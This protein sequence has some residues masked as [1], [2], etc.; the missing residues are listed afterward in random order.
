MLP[1]R[2]LSR[3]LHVTPNFICKNWKILVMFFFFVY[4]MF[5]NSGFGVAPCTSFLVQLELEYA[6]SS[7]CFWSCSSCQLFPEAISTSFRSSGFT[8]LSG[9]SKSCE[10]FFSLLGLRATQLSGLAFAGATGFGFAIGDP[11]GQVASWPLFDM[12]FCFPIRS[13]ERKSQTWLQ[14]NN[15]ETHN[16]ELTKKMI[17]FVSWKKLPVVGMCANWF[18]VSTYLILILG[19]KLILSNKKHR[20]TLTASL[21]SKMYNVCQ[22]VRNLHQTIDQLFV[23]FVSWG[24]GFWDWASHKFPWCHYG[25][26]G[27]CCWLNIIPQLLCPKDREQVTQTYAIQHPEKWLRTL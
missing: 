11:S 20:L 19:S 12:T 7:S 2:K 26:V 4:L 15:R 13:S 24:L 6:F 16:V 17:P 3:L 1:S 18:L 25:W 8:G 10:E 21:S 5:W 14:E 23:F 9:Y 22:C 27:Q